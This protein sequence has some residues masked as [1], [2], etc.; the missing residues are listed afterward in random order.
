MLHFILCFNLILKFGT[1]L[2]KKNE[3]K[4]F[5]SAFFSF[6]VSPAFSLQL[7]SIYGIVT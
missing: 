1:K 7:I 2:L 6:C 5:P 4:N 3:T